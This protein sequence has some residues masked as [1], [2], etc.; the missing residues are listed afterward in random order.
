MV[1][2]DPRMRRRSLVPVGALVRGVPGYV[3]LLAWAHSL[4]PVSVHREQ[5]HEGRV[6][7]V[8]CRPPS[9]EH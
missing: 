8:N 5:N 6:S 1:Q 4:G 7:M 3:L 2:L 9:L